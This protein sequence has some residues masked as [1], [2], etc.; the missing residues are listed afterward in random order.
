MVFLSDECFRDFEIFFIISNYGKNLY[1][2]KFLKTN[3]VKRSFLT[4]LCKFNHNFKSV[5]ICIIFLKE[6]IILN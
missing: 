4:F 3:N 2:Q 6:N 5:K 1:L